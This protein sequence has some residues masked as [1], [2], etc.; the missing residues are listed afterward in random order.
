MPPAG[1]ESM[2]HEQYQDL[3]AVEAVGA[4]TETESRELELHVTTCEACRR[5]LD[6]FREAAALQALALEPVEPPAA[7]RDGVIDGVSPS[8]ALEVPSQPRVIDVRWWA[9]AAVLFLALWGW[10]ELGIRA[11]RETVIAQQALVQRLIEENRV[12]TAH[13]QKVQ[14]QMEALAAP[15]TR[16]FALKG[17][18]MAPAASARVF[19]QSSSRR[20]LVFFYNMPPNPHDKSYELWIVRG[21]K[22]PPRAAG[23]FNVDSQTHQSSVVIDDLPV[24]TEMTGFAV[25][26]EPRGGRPVPTNSNYYV[27]GNAPL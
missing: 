22:A 26:L 27:A 2:T 12:L 15:D 16:T 7:V 4:T 17:Q 8:S 3:A 18:P 23:T 1:I 10:R 6:D 14:E 11:I 19:L 25:T 21:E 20:A 24:G 13:S 5:V 9:A